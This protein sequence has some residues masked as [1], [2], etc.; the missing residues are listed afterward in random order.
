MRKGRL[1]LIAVLGGAMVLSWL[2]GGFGNTARVQSALSFL[3][4]GLGAFGIFA[5]LLLKLQHVRPCRVW[6]F[7]AVGT[8]LNGVGLSLL[9]IDGLF[10]IEPYHAYHVL[11]AVGG[12][13]F[14]AGA[15][16]ESRV[17]PP[18]ESDFTKLH[19]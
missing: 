7:S 11:D 6:G 10:Q 3:M 8:F 9:G 19:L 1:I 5:G 12:T 15:I 16:I 14:V 17:R 13:A 18:R 4:L 2:F